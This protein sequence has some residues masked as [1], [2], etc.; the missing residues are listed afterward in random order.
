MIQFAA[1]LPHVIER[2]ASVTVKQGFICTTMA[3]ALLFG[4]LPVPT[5]VNPRVNA[6]YILSW[7]FTIADKP[8]TGI[9]MF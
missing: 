6:R 9:G 5:S 8:P 2:R 3:D 1:N 7:T 4:Y